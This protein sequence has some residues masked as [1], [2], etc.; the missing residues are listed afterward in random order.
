[1][2]GILPFLMMLFAIGGG[3]ISLFGKDKE[4]NKPVRR[5]ETAKPIARNEERQTS[6]KQTTAMEDYSN[7]KQE[8]LEKL[9]SNLDVDPN[10]YNKNGDAS[11]NSLQ[12]VVRL[13]KKSTPK[14][15]RSTRISLTRSISRQGL[16]ESIVMAEVLGAPRS[17]KPYQNKSYVRNQK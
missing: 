6:N 10:L 8:Q 4:E 3:L 5:A 9:K 12:E 13:D 17:K 7:S 1:M 2:D 11:G 15:K 16:A 14:K